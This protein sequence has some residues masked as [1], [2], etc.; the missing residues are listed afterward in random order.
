MQFFIL[1]Q[2][3]C[4]VVCDFYQIQRL[5]FEDCKGRNALTLPHVRVEGEHI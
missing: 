5:I 2:I 3:A 4:D 1:S